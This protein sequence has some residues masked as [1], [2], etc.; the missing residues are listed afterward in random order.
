MS[1]D[2]QHPWNIVFLAGFVVY[3]G[4]RHVYGSR[5]KSEKSVVRRID[6]LEKGLLAVVALGSL[7]FPVLYLFTPVL[8]FADYRL[9]AFV[10]W[11]GV[12]VMLVA[13]WLFR[14]S[15]ADLGRQWSISLEVREDHRLIT[16]GVYRSI[17]HPMYLAIWLWSLA[18]AL[19][20]ENWLAGYGAL[21][22]FAPMYF[23]RTPREEALMCETFG[24]E[25]RA[26]MQRTGRILPFL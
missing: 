13:L 2:L 7:L 26:Y 12:A 5:L 25:Y 10:P 19:L 24:E 15:H 3:I 17:R 21:L 1:V 6:G 22:S 14:R 20:L 4:I 18:Q 16:H 8:R 23:I 9:P 11:A